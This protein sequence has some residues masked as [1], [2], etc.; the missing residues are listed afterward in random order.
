MAKRG[1]C[2]IGRTWT[3]SRTRPASPRRTCARIQ[4]NAEFRAI[5]EFFSEV[6]YLHLVPQLLKYGDRIGGQRMENDPFGQG[7]LEDVAKT[8]PRTRESRISEDRKSPR[9]GGS[10]IQAT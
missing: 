5:A 6:L 9:Y 2:L 10:P 1:L 3:T 7:F 4:T 8:A